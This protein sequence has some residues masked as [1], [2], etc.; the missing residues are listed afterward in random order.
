MGTGTGPIASDS[1]RAPRHYSPALAG[2]TRWN[3]YS[4]PTTPGQFNLLTTHPIIKWLAIISNLSPPNP[5]PC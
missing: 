5:F 2:A 1:P 4:D 3:V